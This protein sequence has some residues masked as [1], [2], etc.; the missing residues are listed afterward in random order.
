MVYIRVTL[1]V[2]YSLGFDNYIMI[3]IHMEY[4]ITWNDC[5]LLKSCVLPLPHFMG[6]FYTGYD[7]GLLPWNFTKW[8]LLF[9][10]FR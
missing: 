1:D 7:V 8:H 3:C 6:A 4:N 10:S 5:A 2:V 9:K